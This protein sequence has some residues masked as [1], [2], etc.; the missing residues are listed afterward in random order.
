MRPL[1][2]DG[3]SLTKC[4]HLLN[5]ESG[6]HLRGVGSKRGRIHFLKINTSPF[7]FDFLK[8]N[9]SPFARVFFPSNAAATQN[10][11]GY[12]H[13]LLTA[14]S[15]EEPHTGSLEKIRQWRTV[16]WKF[17]ARG[18]RGGIRVIYYW[19]AKDEQIR[20]LY[21]YAKGEQEN[22]TSDQLNQL[23]QIVARW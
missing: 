6:Q 7:A 9:A 17:P 1:L 8:I 12:W 10:T 19:A 5:I 23:L 13:K 14:W 2:H 15:N 22:L 18:K 21:V 3:P 11:H 20:L 16:R 4:V